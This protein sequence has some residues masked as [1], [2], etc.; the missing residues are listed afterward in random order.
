M[1]DIADGIP[2]RIICR[3][4]NVQDVVF[5]IPVEIAGETRIYRK[6]FNG[7]DY[8][9]SYCDECKACEAEAYE[10]LRSFF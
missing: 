10:R 9:F 7:C 6:G 2:V 4:R 8:G 3:K 5:F 1:C